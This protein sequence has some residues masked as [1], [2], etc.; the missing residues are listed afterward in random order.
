MKRILAIGFICMLFIPP[1]FSQGTNSS[2]NGGEFLKRIEYNRRVFNTYNFDSKGEGEKRFFG[3]FNAP[4]EFFY[5]H[6]FDGQSG[7]RLVWDS[8]K[9]SNTIE[10]KF[11]LNFKEI[12]KKSYEKYP[13]RTL[14]S[15]EMDVLP[16]DSLDLISKQNYENMQKAQEEQR[17]LGGNIDSRSFP[18]SNQFADILYKKMVS[19]I[20]N[21]KGSGIAPLIN[22]G[23]RVTFRTVVDDEVWSLSI[24]C[25]Q[26]K[27]LKM[28]DIC[29]QILKD[30]KN[31]QLDEAK[32]IKLLDDF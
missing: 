1:V 11:I 3:D 12:Q 19:I 24:H 8:L 17:K 32:Y 16:K 28:A 29:I 18:V 4:V 7:F 6:S 2:N 21:F 15:S 26:E 14:S 20:G 5:D 30:A 13:L 31:N 9:G 23:Y 10:V 25:P 27:A 22:D